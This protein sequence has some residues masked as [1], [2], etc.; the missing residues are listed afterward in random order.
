MPL[1][2]WLI[3]DF[4]INKPFISYLAFSLFSRIN[5]NG[6]TKT[7]I[8]R[9]QRNIIGN[10]VKACAI[11]LRAHTWIISFRKD[12]FLQRVHI[13]GVSDDVAAAQNYSWV[14][15]VSISVLSKFHWMNSLWSF[16]SIRFHHLKY[17]ASH[18][19][20]CVYFI[21]SIFAGSKNQYINFKPLRTSHKRTQNRPKCDSNE[22]C[23]YEK[24]I[25]SQ[26]EIY[27]SCSVRMS[28]ISIGQRSNQRKVPIFNRSSL[29][30]R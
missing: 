29:E 24:S 3:H 20:Q 26:S 13:D 17:Y 5:F 11:R 1:I 12:F 30:R 27:I 25:F 8:R 14:F 2:R 19:S 7:T 4:M 22:K 10:F 28:G 21:F 6:P 23:E 15:Y 18:Y 9:M 16:V